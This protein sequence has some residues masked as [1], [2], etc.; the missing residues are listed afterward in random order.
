MDAQEVSRE[1]PLHYST[2]ERR[3]PQCIGH[4]AIQA[5]SKRGIGAR[6]PYEDEWKVV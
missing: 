5:A 4:F 3:F 2:S 1:S 6:L